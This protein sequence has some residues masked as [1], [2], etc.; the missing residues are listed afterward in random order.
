[1]ANVV[2]S[3][4]QPRREIDSIDESLHDLLMRRAEI[5][6]EIGR[7]KA[8]DG[9]PAFRPAR[10][11]QL[12]RRLLARHEGALPKGFLVR[13][14]REIVASST[15][16]QGSFLVGYCPIEGQRDALRLANSQFGLDANVV[17]FTSAAQV[18]ASVERGDVSVGLVSLP[19]DSDDPEWWSE[20]E[21][22]PQ[23]RIVARLPWFLSSADAG[24]GVGAFVVSTGEPEESGEDRSVLTFACGSDVSRAR[25]AELAREN[26]LAAEVQAVSPGP[27]ASG[28]RK[29]LVD[30][31]GFVIDD[32][33]RVRKLATLLGD[34]E[35][36]FLGAY[37]APFIEL[38][39]V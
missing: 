34:A 30:V 5:V 8:S 20:L 2:D 15:R 19:S 21:N 38:S 14:W 26:K 36:R 12:L 24:E 27:D 9:G 39:D 33:P 31:A 32:D 37:A 25:F 6:G 11:A 17:R 23:V 22:T 18:I 3:L 7:Q 35:V 10:E 16:L 29:H 13:L 28:G 1:M 4:A